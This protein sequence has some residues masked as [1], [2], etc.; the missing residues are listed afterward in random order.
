MTLVSSNIAVPFSGDGGTPRLFI[1]LEGG[2]SFSSEL[3]VLIYPKN[4]DYV[5]ATV[6]TVAIIGNR[7]TAITAEPIPFENSSESE[8]KFPRPLSPFFERFGDIIAGDGGEISPIFRYDPATDKVLAIDPTTGQRV[9]ISGFALASYGVEYTKA[10]YTPNMQFS[11][12]TGSLVETGAVVAGKDGAVAKLEIDRQVADSPNR[13]EAASVYSL[14]II[15]NQSHFQ[16]LWEYPA[17]WEDDPSFPGFPNQEP[18]PD[19]AVVFE[20]IHEK[21]YVNIFGSVTTER[22]FPRI[23]KPYSGGSNNYRPKYLFRKGDPPEGYE[24]AFGRI[25]F[26]RVFSDL[27]KRW[28]GLSNE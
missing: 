24:S 7:Q 2:V 19:H 23:G 18:D 28:S 1:K 6:G 26:G 13:V 3:P 12:V 8:T 17:G 16:S 27:K 14:A 9:K 15:D 5:K 25:D 10:V 22:F 21:V 11:I 20:R 4:P